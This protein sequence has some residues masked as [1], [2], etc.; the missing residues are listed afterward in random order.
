MDVSAANAPASS[1]AW[2][3]GYELRA[4]ALLSVGFGLVG[5]DR[6]IIFPLFPVMAADLGL[7]YSDLGLISAILALAWG[8]SSIFSGKLSDLIG[9]RRVLVGAVISFSVLVA[10]SGLATGLISLLI[11]R[12]LMGFAEGAY[13]PP[14]I[15]ATVQASKPS[16]KGLNVG[17]QQMA[18]PLFG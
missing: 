14:S 5:L 2:N 4:V 10:S 13:V 18:A 15:V 9:A 3:R 8:L 7:D 11:I 16:R 12:G 1:G 6:F 17:I